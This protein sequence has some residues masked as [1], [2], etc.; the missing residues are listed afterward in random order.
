MRLQA[1]QFEFSFPRPAL[2]MGI[3]NVTPDSFSD[4]GRYLEPGAAVSKALQMASEGADLIDI[5]G[6][7]TRPHATPVSERDELSRVLPVFEGLKGRITVPLSIDTMKPA[8]A[9]AA[10]QAGAS[11][12]NDVNAVARNEE[13]WKIVA[14]TG[15]AYVVMHMQGT[16]QTMQADPQYSDVVEEVGQFFQSIDRGLNGAGVRNEQIIFD[17]G[18]GFGKKVKHNLELLRALNSFTKL[19]RPLLLGVS[20]KSFIGRITGS[21]FPDSLAGS[22]ACA[23]WAVSQGTSIIRTHDVAETVQALRM[24]EAL[25]QAR[26]ECFSRL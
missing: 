20:R 26:N 3:I 14:D 10:L 25:L 7:S 24:T 23:T 6:E 19:G 15:A 2:V 8:V 17:V 11:I 16:P 18:I 1:G 21:A 12:I 13:M 4:G 9:R 5:G 22:L